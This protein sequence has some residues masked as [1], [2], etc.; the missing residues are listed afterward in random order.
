MC[1]QTVQTP[2]D[3]PFIAQSL[4]MNRPMAILEKVGPIAVDI[5]LNGE[6]GVGKEVFAR[7]LHSRYKGGS[8]PFVAVNCAAIPENLV[9]SEFFGH[10]K[11]AFTGAVADRQGRFMEANGGILFLDEVAE[12]PLPMQAKF[13]RALQEGETTP[14]GGNRVNRFQVRVISATNK[15]LRHEVAQG[16]FREDLFYRLFAIEIRIP[17]LRERREDIP[18]LAE[19]FLKV[20][21]TRY[22]RAVDRL[23]KEVL[24]R[25]TEYP[26]PGNVR[27]LLKEIQ[28]IVS[29]TTNGRVAALEH[30][31][32]EIRQFATSTYTPAP[33]D[34]A[35]V[36]LPREIQGLID[37]LAM[38]THDTWAV[39][40]IA[41]GWR[42]GSKRN[43]A[44]REHPCLIPYETLP[45]SEKRIDIEMVTETI[46][47][48]LVLGYR[49]TAAGSGTMAAAPDN[50][51]PATV[52]NLKE[53]VES[54]EIGLILAAIAE[55]GNNRSEAA[56][57]LG[58]TREGLYKKIRRYE[59]DQS[60]SG[61][62]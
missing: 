3:P 16:R 21:A 61:T 50:G 31:S 27:Q 25:F 19:A 60:A 11:G 41:E 54:L 12:M 36:R 23:S 46:K 29:M 59:L 7:M 17:P 55:T 56:R 47:S 39:Q 18:A 33:I 34:T 8:C 51:T 5:F 4:A 49:I 32:E 44:A 28:H 9:E 45:D 38:S 35:S 52:G 26:W 1:K 62:T 10:V 42:F 15:D 20:T 13:L 43:D 57:R 14:V 53:Q 24:Q 22:K 30:C 2:D 40:R 48:I 6:N 58:I 37:H